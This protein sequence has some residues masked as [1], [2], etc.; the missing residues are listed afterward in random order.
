VDQKLSAQSSGISHWPFLHSRS[1]ASSVFDPNFCG[2]RYTMPLS[3]N[4]S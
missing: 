1:K 3:F 4:S 2:L